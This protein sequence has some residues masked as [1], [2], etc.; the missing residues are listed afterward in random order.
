MQRGG[1]GIAKRA[2]EVVAEVGSSRGG[3][4]RAARGMRDLL[5]S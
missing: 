4:Y 5:G 2:A 3:I 1:G